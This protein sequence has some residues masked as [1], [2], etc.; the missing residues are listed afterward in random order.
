MRNKSQ[1]EHPATEKALKKFND[2]RQSFLTEAAVT[3]DKEA[4]QK[5][6]ADLDDRIARIKCND[7]QEREN[8]KGRLGLQQQNPFSTK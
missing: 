3:A 8:A 6:L 7:R 2:L 1:A 4:V 5:K